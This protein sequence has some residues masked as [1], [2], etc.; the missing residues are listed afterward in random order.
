ME[1][2]T[3]SAQNPLCHSVIYSSGCN[4]AITWD[5]SRFQGEITPADTWI[6]TPHRPVHIQ[7]YGTMLVKAKKSGKEVTINFSDTQ[8]APDYQ[9]TM[10][11]SVKL[12][13]KGVIWDQIND[14][15]YYKDTKAVICDI[16]EHYDLAVIEYNPVPKAK[17]T[18]PPT[19]EK[20]AKITSEQPTKITEPCTTE[21]PTEPACKQAPE[22]KEEEILVV[23]KADIKEPQK[24]EIKPENQQPPPYTPPKSMAISV[25]PTKTTVVHRVEHHHH[26]FW[27]ERSLDSHRHEDSIQQVHD[28]DSALDSKHS[29]DPCHIYNPSSWHHSHHT[30]SC[31]HCHVGN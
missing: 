15:L 18:E 27:H 16:E 6:Q 26:H 31:C 29:H 24:P 10:V 5:K 7:G 23:K 21:A 8:Y 11:S 4:H 1:K 19:L 9:V 30:R 2:T 25:A 17:I 20:P 14:R 22:H 12:K 13:K 3:I 28:S